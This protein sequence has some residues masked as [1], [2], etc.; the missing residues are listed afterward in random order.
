MGYSQLIFISYFL[1][2]L[3]V[4]NEISIIFW[5][6]LWQGCFSN[7]NTFFFFTFADSSQNYLVSVVDIW[8]IL[9]FPEG[10]KL[11]GDRSVRR[12]ACRRSS[13]HSLPG[14]R[15]SGAPAASARLL[16]V[17]H[18]LYGRREKALQSGSDQVSN[19][20]W[21]LFNILHQI[22]WSIFLYRVYFLLF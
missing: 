10:S 12:V 18:S 2:Y 20:M 13:F 22:Q 14:R 16:R 5:V 7:W 4:F 9:Y 8:M 17:C 3:S 6:F 21:T 1:T 11:P 19:W 15:T